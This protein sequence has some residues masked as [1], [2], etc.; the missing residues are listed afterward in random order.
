MCG[1]FGIFS[2]SED[3]L[4]D[5]V[6]G[7]F[8]MQ[9]RG[10]D[11]C[12]VAIS[13]GERI[14]LHKDL[15]YVREVFGERPA[16]DFAGQVAIGHVRYP[17]QGANEATNAQPHMVHTLGGPL[18]ALCSNGDLTNYWPVRAQLEAEGIDFLGQNDG[19]LLLK[20]IAFH[21]VRGGLS[22]VESIRR[23]QV[24]V[25]GAYSACLLTRD[26]LIAFRD[27]HAIRPLAIGGEAG[28]W[29]VA[30]ETNALDITR[31]DLIDEVAPGEIIEIGG[32]GLRR[33]PH[34]NLIE[35]REGRTTAAHCSFEHIYFSRPDSIVFG[36]RSYDV[37]KRF[38]AWLAEHDSVE[39]DVVVPVPDSS[40]A[41]ALGYAQ[42]SNLPFEFGLM[43]NHYVGRTFISPDQR[44]RDDKVKLKFNPLRS[45]FKGKRVILID[46]SI[47]RGT[48]SRKLVRMVRSAGAAEVHLRIGSPV[49]RHSCFYGV[50]TPSSDE[51]IGARLE[52]EVI[53]EH[54]TAD[55]LMYM[56]IEGLR[57][58]LGG[59][60]DFC[61]AC[62]DGNYPV[63]VPESK[64][65]LGMLPISG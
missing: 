1:V 29:V 37:R 26:G 46:D 63:A 19:E 42:T 27:V 31:V 33:H 38:G 62:F 17:T 30:S 4:P 58:C 18:M 14:R 35:L 60:D 8:Q 54:L 15:G 22:L 64:F 5:V 44:L 6:N 21:H 61:M 36:E 7:L 41:V 23:L 57:D 47:V 9:H 50:D 10:Q 48:T 16:V 13:D 12:G 39:G 53:R 40:N 56:S 51:L 2:S 20:H 32:E 55:S 65:A 24:E 59:R 25:H 28:K 49:T 11:A 34:P 52:V 45:V 43:R 3:V